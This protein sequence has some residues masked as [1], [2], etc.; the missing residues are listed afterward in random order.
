[1]VPTLGQGA[2]Q[3]V[4]D[5]C[6]TVDEVRRA[7]KAGEALAGVGARVEARRGARVQ[8]VVDFSRDAS[9]TMLA[10]ADPEPDDAQ[11]R[12]RLPAEAHAPLSRRP[13][14]G[15]RER[16][17]DSMEKFRPPLAATSWPRLSRWPSGA[18][19]RRHRHQLQPRAPISRP[20]RPCVVWPPIMG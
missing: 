4:E 1:M 12:A 20:A 11:D 19:Q 10:G 17:D 6:V 18:V 5:A 13:D 16:M 7:L 2:T 3:A 9:D 8:F 14:A 15:R